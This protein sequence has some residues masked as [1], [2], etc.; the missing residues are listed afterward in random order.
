MRA[1]RRWLRSQWSEWR[2][3]ARRQEVADEL[4]AALGLPARPRL[5]ERGNL[6][7]DSNYDVYSD[8]AQIGVLRLVNPYKR[9]PRPT[10]PLPVRGASADARIDHE[11]AIYA[12]GAPRGLTP[13]PLWRAGD[14]LFCRY[15]P[16]APLMAWVREGH[17]VWPL[18]I[19]GSAVLHRLHQEARVSH[20]DASLGNILA[21]VERTAHALV[22]FEYLP[23]PGLGFAEQRIY[24]HLRLVHAS[25]KFIGLAERRDFGAWLRQL[26]GFLDEPM[27][28][29]SLRRIAPG[30]GNVLSDER[31]RA[32]LG[33]LLPE[34]R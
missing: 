27:R 1:T 28:A 26:S 10:A 34:A 21:N 30:L 8:G 32:A 5:V 9:R 22:D 3:R 20:M 24:D 13:H 16:F 33:E 6:G 15:L 17:A 14:A 7:F 31:F 11:F 25:W 19:E 29:A 2:L 18:L 23:V 12:L 4:T